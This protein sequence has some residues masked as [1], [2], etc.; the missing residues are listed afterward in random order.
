MNPSTDT[1][2]GQSPAGSTQDA[3]EVPPAL[4]PAH[5]HAAV[6]KLLREATDR[7]EVVNLVD[8][9]TASLAG[10]LFTFDRAEVTADVIGR[11]AGHLRDAVERQRAQA[12]L[13]E[14]REAGRPPN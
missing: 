13:K 10:V 9:L 14:M 2:L 4:G 8:A 6:E 7:H 3:P 12:E 11:L 1:P 5:Y